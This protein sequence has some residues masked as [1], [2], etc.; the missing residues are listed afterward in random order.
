MTQAGE[1][2]T[3]RRSCRDSVLAAS[4]S[5]A[6]VW[7]GDPRCA[8]DW[9]DEV[10]PDGCLQPIGLEGGEE[11]RARGWGFAGDDG[12]WIVEKSRVIGGFGFE[13]PEE[14]G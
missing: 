9:V 14:R 7:S 11:I 2:Q 8:G 12:R 6:T 5:P 13:A 4:R 3:D 10:R 1:S